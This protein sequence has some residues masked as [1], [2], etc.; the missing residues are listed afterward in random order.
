[1]TGTPRL[2]TAG[3]TARIKSVKGDGK[4]EA[5]AIRSMDDEGI[6]GKVVHELSYREAIERNITAPIKVIAHRLPPEQAGCKIKNEAGVRG[7]EEAC[8][9][10]WR[11]FAHHHCYVH[12]NSV[13]SLVAVQGETAR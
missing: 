5:V 10:S 12:S 2:F 13:A 6:F 9:R 7:Y 11:S 3:S 1:M 8:K 4:D